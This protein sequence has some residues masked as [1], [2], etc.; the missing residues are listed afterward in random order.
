MMMRFGRSPLLWPPR[1][2]WPPIGRSY[3]WIS[4][5]KRRPHAMQCGSP[6]KISFGATKRACRW[7][8]TRKTMCRCDRMTCSAMYSGCTQQSRHRTTRMQQRH[9]NGLNL[10]WILIK[11]R[12]PPPYVKGMP[13]GADNLDT[14]LGAVFLEFGHPFLT[15]T[16]IPYNMFIRIHIVKR[17]I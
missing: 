9:E 6:S 15:F 5:G 17:F 14:C 7:T 11:L 10:R 8:V 4:G 1:P 13:W 16:D 2:S 12:Q 3:A